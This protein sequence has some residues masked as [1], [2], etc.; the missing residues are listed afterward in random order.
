MFPYVFASEITVSVHFHHFSM[1][2]YVFSSEIT[3]YMHFHHFSCFYMWFTL[4]IV[5]TKKKKAKKLQDSQHML[6]FIRYAIKKWPLF[7]EIVR[8]GY[9]ASSCFS[10]FAVLNVTTSGRHL[11]A[12]LVKY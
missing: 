8:V 10:V 7:D 11:S 4:R 1:F 12:M 5:Y 6:F 9:P 2:L 3:V